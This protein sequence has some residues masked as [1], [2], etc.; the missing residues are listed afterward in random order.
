MFSYVARFFSA[1]WAILCALFASAANKDSSMNIDVDV[2]SA[3]T[4][5]EAGVDVYS[6]L[7]IAQT[8]AQPCY[9]EYVE[10]LRP[11]DHFEVLAVAESHDIASGS[12]LYSLGRLSTIEE[13]DEED[14]IAIDV[15]DQEAGGA[16][17]M[18]DIVR[19]T[20][21]GMLA[22]LGDDIDG[23]YEDEGAQVSL[24]WSAT[25]EYEEYGYG[26]E[27]ASY[28]FQAQYDIAEFCHNSII[29]SSVGYDDLQMLLAQEGEQE[30]DSTQENI[31][32]FT[33]PQE[34]TPASSRYSLGRLSTIEE[35][36]EE[37][38]DMA[39]QEAAPK[40]MV[41]RMAWPSSNDIEPA[42]N[43][44]KECEI[45]GLESS[46][47]TLGCSKFG[48]YPSA[49]AMPS[50]LGSPELISGENEKKS[51]GPRPSFV[52]DVFDDVYAEECA[53]SA[54]STPAAVTVAAVE[55]GADVLFPKISGSI[56]FSELL[57]EFPTADKLF[58]GI[59][60]LG[61]YETLYL[62]PAPLHEAGFSANISVPVSVASHL[63]PTG[64]NSC[65]VIPA[66]V[67]SAKS[68][69]LEF[70]SAD[71]LFEGIPSL[72]SFETLYLKPASPLEAS[73]PLPAPV[74]SSPD[75]PSMGETIPMPPSSSLPAIIHAGFVDDSESEYLED[76]LIPATVGSLG[77]SV[78]DRTRKTLTL[79][80]SEG[81]VERT[82]V[83][84][85]P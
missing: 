64:S 67:D 23:T 84:E 73:I 28:S 1:I 36:D 52:P 82:A 10:E 7:S 41:A 54:G 68:T 9:L 40:A 33:G 80:V 19:T 81:L 25:R 53:N 17:A 85:W 45:H 69:R 22:P 24:Y 20:W 43:E 6:T 70:P 13:V 61:S 56:S 77:Y 72:G 58:E 3:A 57:R 15:K 75:K 51:S 83:S 59:P 26:F 37:D 49:L 65:A 47:M 38:I 39:D 63:L 60:C 29:S 44:D 8:T 14:D 16:E 4:D 78:A 48:Y 42:Y 66:A 5:A 31:D 27:G 71:K 55:I 30:E 2:P 32:A 18:A 35:V 62:K 79:Q 46:S 12:S 21:S 34:L 50:F 76:G 11:R 74:T